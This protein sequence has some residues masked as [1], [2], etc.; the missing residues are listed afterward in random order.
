[1]HALIRKKD[2]VYVAAT[3]ETL[4][5]NIASLSKRVDEV[6][7]DIR[8]LR[9]DNKTLRDK[10]DHT[11]VTLGERIDLAER[12]LNQKIDELGASLRKE[13]N[14]KFDAFRKEIDGKLD[15][16]GKESSAK[17]DAIHNRFQ[18]IDRRFDAI[19]KRFDEVDKRID[20]LG[21]KVEQ[22]VVAVAKIHGLHATVLWVCGGF[23]T[24]VLAALAIG[25]TFGWI[26][27]PGV[28]P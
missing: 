3:N 5:A 12:R 28:T 14:E 17:F 25:K 18:A 8:E 24:L 21:D 10:I 7:I 26:G 2:E 13:F 22:L 11:N 20:K 6:T 16:L 27:A 4:E 19:D 15:T 23:V 1:M 9:A